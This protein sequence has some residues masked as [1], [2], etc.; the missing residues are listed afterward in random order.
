MLDLYL[1]D[2]FNNQDKEGF[3]I[4]EPGIGIILIIL[5]LIAISLAISCNNGKPNMQII[6]TVV[7]IL[8]PW[9]YLLGY[10]VYHIFLGNPC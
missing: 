9:L 3:S 1:V 10:L 5:W 2:K 7:A 4:I 8:S 6:M